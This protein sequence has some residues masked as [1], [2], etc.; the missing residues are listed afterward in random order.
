[1]TTLLLQAITPVH[2]GDG[3]AVGSV[4]RPILRERHTG[5]STLPGSSLKGAARAWAE[6]ADRDADAIARIFGPDDS[7]AAGLVRFGPAVLLLAPVRAAKGGFLL[8]TCPLALARFARAAG[9][10]AAV[11]TPGP[12]VALLAGKSADCVVPTRG[13]GDHVE[14]VVILE[15]LAWP[16]RRD[17]AVGD[18]AAL[19]RQWL[20][21]D[22]P[23][24]HLCVVAD[25]VFAHAARAWCGV[26]TRAAVDPTTG[27][28]E[29]GKLFTIEAANPDTVWWCDLS[30]SLRL[31]DDLDP[32]SVLPPVGQAWTVGGGATYGQGRICWHRRQ[33]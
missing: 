20:G 9:L 30:M 32:W 31:G 7:S 2:V 12:D 16:V 21:D 8:L 5:W 28:V 19:L 6:R 18:W 14:G 1:M 26:R 22:A 25:D 27:V 13:V 24:E 3:T 29:E 15:D 23:M 33:A 10:E 11:P 17:E 4:D